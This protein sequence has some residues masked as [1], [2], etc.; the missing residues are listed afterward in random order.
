MK[1]RL[2][3]NFLID[4]EQ[5]LNNS[6]LQKVLQ[7]KRNNEQCIHLLKFKSF[8][9]CFELLMSSNGN[10]TLLTVELSKLAIMYF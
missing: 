9:D 7:L 4:L 10:Q 3:L 6:N 8:L 2:N 1:N 5:F